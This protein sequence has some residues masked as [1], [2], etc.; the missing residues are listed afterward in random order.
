MTIP[1]VTKTMILDTYS[2][3]CDIENQLGAC[4]R[5]PLPG[6]Y[7]PGQTNPVMVPG[8]L[9][10]TRCSRSGHETPVTDL[11][12]AT[13]DI[14][15]INHRLVISNAQLARLKNQTTQPVVALE[16][17]RDVVESIIIDLSQWLADRNQLASQDVVLK[18]VSHELLHPNNEMTLIWALRQIELMTTDIRRQVV[19][20]IDQDVWVMHF[21]KSMGRDTFVEKTID[22]RVY[23]WQRKVEAGLWHL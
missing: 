20:F 15:D 4:L 2:V 3:A 8:N 22:Y 9:Y 19:G 13:S 1:E 17:V 21:Q 18:H 14:F 10:Y 5:R 6:I 7:L 11:R 12:Q 16:L 23:D